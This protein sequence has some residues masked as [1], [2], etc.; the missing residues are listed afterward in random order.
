MK[1]RIALDQIAAGS[2][3]TEDVL[4]DDK[5]LLVPANV[6]VKQKDL[7]TLRRWGVAYVITEGSPIEEEA[8]APAAAEAAAVDA[9]SQGFA[10]SRE[11][12]LRYTELEDRLT[13]ILERIRKGDGV[14]SKSVDIISQGVVALVRE[15]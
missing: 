2:R 10:G 12:Y 9:A 3:F 1:K 7:D 11:L 4:I 14:E 13:P 15:E 6:P 5:N 8:A